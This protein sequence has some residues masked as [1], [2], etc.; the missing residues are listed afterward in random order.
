MG[1]K[2]P[3]RLIS[4]HS[5]YLKQHAYNP[6]DWYPWGKEAFEKAKKE[7]KLLIISIGYAS[8]HWCHVMEKESFEDEEIAEIM[9]T[10]FVSIKVDRE[11][12][13][14]VDAIYMDA[15]QVMTGQGGWPLNV[16]ALPD[17]RPIVGGTYFPKA[18]WKNLCLHLANLWKNDPDRVYEYAEKLHQ[19][20]QELQLDGLNLKPTSVSDK[21]LKETIAQW[22]TYMDAEWGGEKKT[23]KFILPSNWITLL[24]YALV[25]NDSTLR[26]FVFFTL[27][28]IAK[29]GIFDHVGG[30]FARYSTD[31]FWHIPHFE[32]MLYD[33]AQLL[34]LYTIAY[35]VS[36]NP[37][38]QIVVEKTVHFLFTELSDGS[39]FYS[40]LDADSEGEEGKYYTWTYEELNSLL[41]EACKEEFL[42]LFQIQPD[43]NWE[44]GKNVLWIP[45]GDFPVN[46]PCIENALNILLQERKK[47]VPPETDTKI[48]T[49]YNALTLK[50]LLIAGRYLDHPEWIQKAIHFEQIL[51]Q[52]LYHPE[53]GLAHQYLPDTFQPAYLEDYA[54][55]IDLLIEL[56]SSTGNPSYITFAQNLLKQVFQQ[57]DRFPPY[58]VMSPNSPLI[59]KAPL[60][61][62][63]VPS[64]NS[65]MAY[66]LYRLGILLGEPSYLQ[67]AEK[68]VSH[69]ANSF[70]QHPS[71][72]GNWLNLFFHFHYP[73]Y[74]VVICGPNAK[75]QA[76]P[77]LSTYRPFLFVCFTEQ[78]SN[79]PIFQ[80]RFPTEDITLFYVCERGICHLPL[81]DQEK[82]LKQV[83]QVK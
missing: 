81:R 6:V 40:A 42:N 30:G 60:Y 74:E 52:K 39:L 34:L 38:F 57:F 83:F 46:N 14:D 61:D 7:N 62:N 50:A 9:N 10:H 23:P 79:L 17:G 31:R 59:L 80:G 8:C 47:R 21:D 29:G 71:Y 33:N 77:F 58:F 37:V 68:M 73:S 44:D 53:M 41:P 67:R 36:K 75:S 72:F 13:P 56:F 54:F 11:E 32:K 22:K 27:E 16:F 5:P 49:G 12:H 15:V 25:E 24:N 78:P 3:N 19:V 48:L 64:P 43:G 45:E 26:Q 55:Y 28:R 65:I 2:K 20:L 66:N 82:A 35:A 51:R 4:Q 70:L 63:V 1:Q 69:L 18:Q 76:Q